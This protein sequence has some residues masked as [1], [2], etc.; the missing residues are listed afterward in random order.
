MIADAVALA[1]DLINMPS[2][3]KTPGWLAAQAAATAGRSGLAVRIRD[4]AEL[5]GA[6]F[7]GIV[8]VGAGSAHPPRLIELTYPPARTR[9]SSWRARGSRS[10]AAG[11]P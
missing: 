10:T 11:C 9:T 2:D 8:A 1:R 6:G 4:E 7:G 3:V 5:A